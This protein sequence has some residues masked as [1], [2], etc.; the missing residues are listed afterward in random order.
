[1]KCIAMVILATKGT[2]MLGGEVAKPKQHQLTA[3]M[4][5]D[6]DF[7]VIYPAQMFAIKLFAEI[8]LKLQWRAEDSCPSSVDVIK[9][10][11]SKQTPRNQHPG[12]VAYALPYEGSHIVVLYDRVKLG[13]PHTYVSQVLAYVLVHEITHIIE[14]IDRHSEAGIMRAKWD[15][16]DNYEMSRMKLRF[17]EDD[18]VLIRVGLEKRAQ[19]E[20]GKASEKT[21]VR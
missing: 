2:S 10:S 5:R 18:I 3:C 4:S 19:Q 9:V 11:I 8:G 17:A 21:A 7:A 6:T 20:R 15:D 12:A 14:G 13:V 1:M 16:A